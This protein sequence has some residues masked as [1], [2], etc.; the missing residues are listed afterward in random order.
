MYEVNDSQVLKLQYWLACSSSSGC[1]GVQTL[2]L[3]DCGCPI[4]NCMW[5]S[6]DC[7]QRFLSGGKYCIPQLRCSLLAATHL[8]HW[9]IFY[10]FRWKMKI[11]PW[12]FKRSLAIWS[13][14][15][16]YIFEDNTHTFIHRSPE[17]QT[18]RSRCL[19]CLIIYAFFWKTFM[20]L[21]ATE[22]LRQ[23]TS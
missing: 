11:H 7:R 18:T 13:R 23:I 22:D 6:R 2:A 10:P 14:I 19:T 16:Y 4:L 8:A 12:F 5:V 20:L 1:S 21:I 15:V 17:Q 3:L 9:K